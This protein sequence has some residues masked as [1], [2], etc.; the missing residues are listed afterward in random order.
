MYPK[1]P[2]CYEDE[3]KSQGAPNLP[4]DTREESFDTQAM[5]GSLQQFLSWNL[6]EY[7]LCEFLIGTQSQSTREGIL[8]AVG[9]SYFVLYEEKTETYVMCDIYAVKF[10][11]FY[12][13]GRRPLRGEG[14]TN[15]RR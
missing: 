13:P 3:T 9:M 10:V 8:Y 2:C 4:Q 7:V 11:T 5:K 6:G 1:N 14:Q 12:R 15:R